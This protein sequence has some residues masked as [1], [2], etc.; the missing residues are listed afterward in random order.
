MPLQEEFE[1]QGNF[2]FKYRSHFPNIILIGGI[3][4]FYFTLKIQLIHLKLIILIFVYWFLFRF[5]R[6]SCYSG[7]YSCKYIG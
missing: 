6:P 3:I 1:S 4:V 5:D 7:I 2:L